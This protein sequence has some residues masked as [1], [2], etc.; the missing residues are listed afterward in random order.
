MSI[1]APGATAPPVPGLEVR[2]GASLLYFYKV[3]CPV[4][5]MTAPIAERIHQAL[6]GGI[7]GIG[8][9]PPERLGEFG[10]EYGVSFESLPDLPPYPVSEA[11]GI[12]VV[13]TLVLVDSGSVAEVAESWDRDAW[14]RVVRGLSERL[15]EPFRPVSEPEDGLPSFRPG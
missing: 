9:D 14:N 8:Q 10:G 7:S 6:P 15:G 3:T 1:I 12:R 4:C 13:P 11:Y 5:Q 2:D